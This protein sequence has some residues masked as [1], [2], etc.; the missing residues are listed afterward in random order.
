MVLLVV[1][2][3]VVSQQEV[4]EDLHL[5][6]KVQVQVRNIL[7]FDNEIICKCLPIFLGNSETLGQKFHQSLSLDSVKKINLVETL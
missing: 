5:E 4:S 2:F 7:P 6:V 1:L 3:L